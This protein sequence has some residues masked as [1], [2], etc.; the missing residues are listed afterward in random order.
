MVSGGG[1]T[2]FF[3]NCAAMKK[4][5]TQAL[6][7]HEDHEPVD[8]RAN[9]VTICLCNAD[10]LDRVR[11][12]QDPIPTLMYD[13]GVWKELTAHSNRLLKEVRL[14]DVRREV[15]GRAKGA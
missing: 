11:L 14:E 5:V 13:D 9:H 12:G 7:F 4:A 15:L 1:S 10:R 3:C 6:L 8:P 2:A